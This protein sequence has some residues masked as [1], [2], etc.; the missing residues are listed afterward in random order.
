[1]GDVALVDPERFGLSFAVHVA[2]ER[3]DLEAIRAFEASVR[4][5]PAVSQGYSISGDY[6]FLLIVHA[7][8]PSA[9]E[10]WGRRTLM[11]NPMVKRYSSSVIWSRTKFSARFRP[12]IG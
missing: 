8:S 4:E 7:V 3:E 12:A 1:M 11:A 9:F 6:D 10:Q 2:F 5:E